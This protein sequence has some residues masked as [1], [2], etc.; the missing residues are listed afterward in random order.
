MFV[1]VTNFSHSRL[2]CLLVSD[3]QVSI[4]NHD[5]ELSEEARRMELARLSALQASKGMGDDAPRLAEEELERLMREKELSKEAERLRAEEARLKQEE[6]RLRREEN[7]IKK[8]KEK[9]EAEEHRKL[10]EALK[11]QEEMAR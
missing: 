1:R 3:L 7:R 11:T 9:Q 6:E 5:L 10:E 8:L 4:S 2:F